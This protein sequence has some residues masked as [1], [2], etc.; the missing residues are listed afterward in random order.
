MK[1]PTTSFNLTTDIRLQQACSPGP[2]RETIT[3]HE[4][5]D[6][7]DEFLVQLHQ[8]TEFQYRT[9]ITVH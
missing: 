5:V 3:M 8:Q 1:D 7:F 4:L 2:T 9:D 6:F